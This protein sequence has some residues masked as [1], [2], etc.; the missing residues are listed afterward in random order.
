[1][2]FDYLIYTHLATA[3]DHRR[4]TEARHH[5]FPPSPSYERLQVAADRAWAPRDGRCPAYRPL[6]IDDI[7][8]EAL[9]A[10]ICL[11]LRSADA[12]NMLIGAYDDAAAE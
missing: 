7:D 12:S 9:G 3:S 8:H 10:T 11:Y 5:D 4:T 2:I 1:M 6:A